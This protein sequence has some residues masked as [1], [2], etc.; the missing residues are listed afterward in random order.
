MIVEQFPM[1]NEKRDEILMEI[2]G[3]M[4]RS[5][6]RLAQGEDERKLLFKDIEGNGTPGLKQ[7]LT[8]VETR[9]SEH[10][11]LHATEDK[12]ASRLA[13]ALIAKAAIACA[14]LSTVA[15]IAVQLWLSCG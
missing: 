5:D 6:Q 4:A 13:T 14:L 7:R 9:F 11:T 8:G 3:F 12:R 1:T 10:V 15:T 2:H